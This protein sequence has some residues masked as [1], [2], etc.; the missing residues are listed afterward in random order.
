MK[1]Q[2]LIAWSSDDY[3]ETPKMVEIEVTDELR[4]KVKLC[5]ELIKEHDLD[6]IKINIY[7]EF[8]DEGEH[9]ATNDEDFEGEYVANTEWRADTMCLNIT[10]YGVYFYAQNKWSAS[11]QIESASIDELFTKELIT[12][13]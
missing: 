13:Q 3:S 2:A 11:D 5:Q 6:C 10:T 8:F 4:T 1:I 12:E 7:G 9:E